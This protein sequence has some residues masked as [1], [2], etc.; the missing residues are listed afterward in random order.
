MFRILDY[1]AKHLKDSINILNVKRNVLYQIKAKKTITKTTI[2]SAISSKQVVQFYYHGGFRLVEPCCYGLLS[3]GNEALLCYQVSGYSE[4]GDPIGWKLFRSSEISR[5]EVTS[6]HFTFI[7]SG[8]ASRYC[9]LT[10]ICCQ[11]FT[12]MADESEPEKSTKIAQS[13]D[14]ESQSYAPREK[15]AASVN[16]HHKLMR[17]FRLSHFIF[18]S[19]KKF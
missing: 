13:S 2:C 15:Y 11:A 8:Y 10:T 6:E 5:L 14:S 17:R 4:F 3:D 16:N 9:A 7:K 19:G 12:D 18:P 1:L